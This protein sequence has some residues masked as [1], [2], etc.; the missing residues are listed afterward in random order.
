[1]YPTDRYQFFGLI[2][3]SNVPLPEL[4]PANGQEPE[5]TFQ[6]LPVAQCGPASG[7]WFHHW[8]LP[9]GTIWLSCAKQGPS[10]WLH[11]PALADFLV[12]A[13]GKEIRCFPDTETPMETI[14]HLFLDQ[15]VPRVLSQQGRLVLH[16]SA[17]AAP[18]GAIAFLGESGQGKSTLCASFCESGYPLLADDC[19]LTT[20]VR[21]RF[22]GVP[23][24]PGLRLWPDVAA[25]LLGQE[26]PDL[27][28]VAHYTEKKRLGP[29]SGPLPFCTESV[30][31]ARLYLLASSDEATLPPSITLVPLSR[32]E[33]FLELVRHTYRL[34]ITDRE[35]LRKDFERLS[36]LTAAPLFRRLTIPRDLALLP[37][38]RA[39]IL[40]DLTER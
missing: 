20:E 35:H 25:A 38:V 26:A 4:V 37:A 3:R 12:S 33:A 22:F 40:A 1:M 32:R 17:V 13:S 30:P 28:P 10:Y 23:S 2:L 19:L 18:E 5:C 9:N 16:A 15:V 29:S 27:A 11:F 31:L 8:R 36:R 34:D 21:G 39:A 7:P 14:R 24:Y 6:L